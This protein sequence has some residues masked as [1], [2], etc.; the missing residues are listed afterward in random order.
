MRLWLSFAWNQWQQNAGRV[1]GIM[2]NGVPS[3]EFASG[4]GRILAGVGVNVE[5]GKIAGGQVQA[6]AVPLNEQVAGG[7]QL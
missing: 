5:P 2:E 4:T 3:L 1:G 7:W 6:D